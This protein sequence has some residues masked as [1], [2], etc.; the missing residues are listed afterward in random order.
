[1]RVSFLGAIHRVLDARQADLLAGIALG[2]R[3]RLPARV[4][5]DFAR[6]GTIHVL[7]TAG[8]HVGIVAWALLL[9]WKALH[10][11]RRWAALMTILCLSLYALAAG[12]RPAVERAV[13]MACLYLAA[14]VLDREPDGPT[15]L[16]AAALWLL[17]C[18]PEMIL[19][20][21]FQLSFA[22]VAVIFAL[23]RALK[24]HEEGAPAQR[25]GRACVARRS[26][27]LFLV[28]LAAQVGAA[29]LTAQYFHTFSAV[30]L[31]ANLLV[32]PAVGIILCA[33]LALWPLSLVAPALA[34]ALAGCTV[35]P[36]LAGV[37][38]VVRGLADLPGASWSV[39]SPGWPLVVLF[40]G[41]IFWAARELGRKVKRLPWREPEADLQGGARET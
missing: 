19:D 32:V 2:A 27:G 41:L 28:S 29:P 35:G 25:G 34:K 15:A 14:Y 1:M 6:T 23:L 3:S 5:D 20:V 12:G 16:G 38:G 37:M 7:A 18:S 36:L 22:T 30:A 40:Y 13:L 4:E 39:S 8:L 24:A 10:L 21:G 9:F 11:P 26:R 17:G 33:S 31:L